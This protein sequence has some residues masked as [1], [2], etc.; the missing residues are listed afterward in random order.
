MWE[1]KKRGE[2]FSTETSTEDGQVFVMLAGLVGGLSEQSK[3]FP[4]GREGVLFSPKRLLSKPRSRS[5]FWRE[6]ARQW[7]GNINKVS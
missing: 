4:T 6:G 2:F 7:A 5:T 3:Q 1:R